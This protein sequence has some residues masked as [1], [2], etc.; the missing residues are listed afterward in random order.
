VELRQNRT[1]SPNQVAKSL[2]VSEASI[3]RWCDKGILP[4]TKTAGGHR[5][6][7]VYAVLDFARENDFALAQPEVLGLPPS[8][9]SGS[10]TLDQACRIYS[11]SLEQ[12]DEARCLQLALDLRLA[13][14]DMAV[15]GDRVI[16][17]AF[18]HLG[19]RWEHGEAEVYQE[20]RGV[21]ITR[22]ILSRLKDTLAPPAPA[23]PTAIGTTPP[24]DPYSLP[25]QLCELVLIEQGWQ[26]RFLGSELPLET[27]AQA[28]EDLRPRVLWLSASNLEAPQRFIQDY[29]RLYEQ[30]RE[31]QCA[32]VI[33]GSAWTD[34]LRREIQYASYGDRL[35]HLQSF[36][37]SLYRPK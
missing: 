13:G 2:G 11:Q 6:I 25:G 37:Q 9:G 17:P 22:H 24:G 27:V 36:A 29:H 30:C 8:V 18:G 34:T 7:P 3:K 31:R 4:F 20:R 16:A 28:V 10:R 32:V 19:Q 5:R 21:E 12:G 1:F 15:I 35:Q 14:H 26:A 23:A 33:G